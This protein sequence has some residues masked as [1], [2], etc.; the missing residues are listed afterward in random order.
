[1]RS[2][3]TLRVATAALLLACT[4]LAP[5]SGAQLLAPPSN[6]SKPL[7]AI[8]PEPQP[9]PTPLPSSIT[10]AAV[11]LPDIAARG[12]AAIQRLRAIE[13]ETAP[14]A[15]SKEIADALAK[16]NE[17]LD[18]GV[19]A[20]EEAI[21]TRAGLDRLLDL[22]RTLGA[23]REEIDGWQV[24]TKA[25]AEMLE[26]RVAELAALKNTW[27]LTLESARNEKA[28]DAVL[29]RIRDVRKDVR[30]VQS[31]IQDERSAALTQQGDVAR[32]WTTISLLL[33]NVSRARWEIR[34]RLFEA[35]RRPL[36]I[37]ARKAQ[38]VDS[39][40][41]RVRDAGN[42]DRESLRSFAA[43]SVDRIRIHGLLFAGFLAL[44]LVL[45]RWAR[46]RRAAGKPIGPAPRVYE[47]PISVALLGAL[48][49][50]PS[51]YPHAPLVLTGLTG[52]LILIP[53]L[54]LLFEVF[55]PELRRLWFAV[56][57]FYLVDRLR[58]GVQ[59][60]ELLERS[61]FLLEMFGATALVIWL[62]RS[63]RLE[64]LARVVGSSNWLGRVLRG[65]A[66]TFAAAAAADA[67]GYF[68]LGKVL[69]EGLLT[70]VYVGVVLYG[71]VVIV[72]PIVPAVLGSEPLA[73]LQVISR[74]RDAIENFLERAIDW[75][76]IGL[77]AYVSLDRLTLADPV[78]DLLRWLIF[79]P[80]EMGAVAISLGDVLA[81][82]AVVGV[83]MLL[84]RALRVLL[85]EDVLPRTSLGR[86]I[87]HAISN[88]AAYG[89]LFLGFLLAL[90]AAGIDL[91]KVTVLAGAF[92]VGIGFGLQNIVNNF[93]S[94]L[95]L[96]YERP[97][98][99]GDVVEVGSLTGEVK[100]IG[101]RSSTLRT[102]QGAEVIV[103][104]ANLI[105]EQVVN[106][107]LSDRQRRIELPV[108]VAYGTDPQRVLAIL[109]EVAKASPEVLEDPPPL[110][111]F[112]GFGDSALNF[113][114]RVWTGLTTYLEV[115]SRI[116]I[117]L[118]AALREA[119][120]EIPFPQ[121]DL[122]IKSS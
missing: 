70:S 111:L 58:Y 92:G 1:M 84:S 87:P 63:D 103:P 89:V 53:T 14:D 39:V 21:E 33:D 29:D 65:M 46:R 98:Q 57:G 5:R 75:T 59:S 118:N 83:A 42:R 102:F 38:S 114:L 113:E 24:A 88:T 61:L 25:R 117:A 77:W 106:W 108:G 23:H 86:G 56:A 11:A 79:T 116:A 62:M 90:G 105:A 28:P 50:T 9:T 74:Y 81:F 64:K 110:A 47:S 80:V 40:L 48:L 54:V 13:I 32:L 10:P 22:E 71:A 112:R 19:A 99:I 4:S 60:V 66:L 51:L 34:G 91:S 15:R 8:P 95:I 17:D 45:R 44:A 104:N 85:E 72:G 115:H 101:I 31:K 2:A 73:N 78:L 49:A 109:L 16:R 100:R 26:A 6:E 97:I 43:L 3:R 82:G 41:K 93:I 69:G 30:A 67:F 35:D 68:T 107:T 122:H 20:V 36:W 96:L 94:G 27:D 119:A 18:K 12:E 7:V 120:I 55:A 52:L 121:R 37:A 76:A